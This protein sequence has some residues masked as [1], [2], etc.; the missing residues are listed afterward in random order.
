MMVEQDRN[1][2][3]D[4]TGEN[5]SDP[6][7]D[8]S[9]PVVFGNTSSQALAGTNEDGMGLVTGNDY[10]ADPARAEA[11]TKVKGAD[12]GGDGGKSRS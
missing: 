8:G 2:D 11:G 3:Q 5:G 12:A 10:V 7:G 6:P 1:P 9:S 4:Q